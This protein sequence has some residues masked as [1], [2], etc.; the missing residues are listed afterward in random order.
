[1]PRLKLQRFR[2]TE[3]RPETLA[4][5]VRIYASEDLY[6]RGDTLLPLTAR[7]LFGRD[8]PLTLDLGSGRG[9]FLVEQA[10]AHPDRL[11]VGIEIHWKSVWDAVN[12][13]EAARL[14]NVRIVRA[15]LRRILGK[16]PDRSV[17]EAWVLFPPPTLEKKRLRKDILSEANIA[18]LGRILED[19]ARLRFVTD[20]PEYFAWKVELIRASGAFEDAVISREFEGGLTRFQQFWEERSI[21]SLRY[22]A[23]RLP[24]VG[25]DAAPSA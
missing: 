19:G 16:V 2:A 18:H 15:D 25:A 7:E 9:E 17:A 22:E 23:L 21:A 11:F 12:R 20:Q 24:R 1:M 3:P 5:Y 10:S 6:H 4:R 14:D 13:A 8:R